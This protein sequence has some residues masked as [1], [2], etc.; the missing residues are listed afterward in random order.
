[1]GLL[2]SFNTFACSNVFVHKNGFAVTARTMDFPFNTGNAMALGLAGQKNE[3]NLNITRPLQPKALKWT[4]HYDFLGQTWLRSN[5][6]LDGINNA[7]VYAG[8]LYLP[9]FTTYPSYSKA[10]KRPVLGVVD[11]INYIL[12]TASSTKQAVSELQRVQIIAS[13]AN[14]VIHGKH[15]TAIIPPIHLVIRD[16][17]GDSAVVEWLDGKTVIYQHAGPVLTNAPTYAWQAANAERYDYVSADNANS[18]YQGAYMNGSGFTGIPGDF[19]PPSRFARAVQ[20][21]HNLP[22]PQNNNEAVEMALGTIDNIQVP[23]GTNHSPTFWKSVS[24]LNHNTYYYRAMY[25]LSPEYAVFG[26][27]N[28]KVNSPP[29][30]NSWTVYDLPKIAA[31][32]ALQKNFTSAVTQPGLFYKASKQHPLHIIDVVKQLTSG[33][34]IKGQKVD[35]NLGVKKYDYV[36][37]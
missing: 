27:P 20:I 8:F 33:P 37:N 36:Q 5:I 18:K 25:T 30:G 17:S 2:L 4:N 23:L 6:V 28:V 11:V 14:S 34:A 12:G 26:Q 10:D 1:M 16:K 21:I 9:N 22:T 35:A 24:D 29:L 31:S 32:K 15:N 19:S 13:A 3:S 7:G